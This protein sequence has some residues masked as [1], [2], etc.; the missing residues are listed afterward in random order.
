MAGKRRDE[1]RTNFLVGLFVVGFGALLITSLFLVAISEGVLSEKTRLRAHFRTVSGLTKASKVQLAG[2]EIGVVEEVSFISPTYACNPVSEDLGRFHETRSDDCEP[3]LFCAVM[4]S[5]SGSGSEAG[6][7]G[8]GLCAELQDFNG[9]PRAYAGCADDSSCAE[10]EVCLTRQFRQ[11]Y[12]RVRWTGPEGV[13]APFTTEHRRVE[14]SMRIDADKL[15]YIRAD[16]RATIAS[17]GVL[18]DQLINISVGGSEL[19]IE[20]DGRIQSSPS[21]MEELNIFKDQIGGIIDKVD[22]SLSG[23]SGL[24]TSLNNENTKRDLQGIL[25]NANEITRQI[26]DGDGLIGA[27]F[28]EPEY[29]DEFGRTLKS[30]RHS[31]GQLDET[32]STVNNQ[33]GPAL[34]NVSRAAGNVSDILEDLENPANQS[35]IGRALHDP[36]LGQDAA[37]AVKSAAG[38]VDSAHQAIRDLQVVVAEVRH[39]VTAGEGTIGK[40]LKD[41]KAYDDLVKLLGN[42]ERV[43]VVKKLVRFVIE[44]DEAKD[45]ARP[46][47][48]HD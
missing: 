31:A 32:L 16:S 15:Q 30:V 33:A 41:P 42:I 29:K 37:D 4:P 27:L 18:G 2:K 21:L 3:T 6:S 13:C 11:R 25:A 12:K 17:N 7:G 10:G 35:V 44:Q 47:A 14:V 39:S 8:E 26:K 24:F 22:T 20:P 9:D 40:L 36:Q 48:A 23:I 1:Q 5:G 38:A 19:H 34:R 46:T 45:S 43:N 28:N